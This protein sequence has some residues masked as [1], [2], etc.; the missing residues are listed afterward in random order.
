M[1]QPSTR[2][3][4]FD[5]LRLLAALQVAFFHVVNHLGVPLDR[6]NP[7]VAFASK[8][9]GVPIFFVVSGFLIS[10]S[11]ERS[12]RLASYARNRALRIYPALWVCLAVGIASA[13]LVGGIDFLRAD[14]IPWLAAQVTFGQFYN[15]DF[16][17]GYGVG[18]LNGSLWTIPVELQFYAFVPLLYAA[19]SLGSRR[20]NVAL[21]LLAATSLGA[22]ALYLALGGTESEVLAVKLFG[23]SLAPYL[24]MFLIGVLLQRNFDQVGHL[25]SGKGLIWL[26]A[27]AAFAFGGEG[28]GLR[29]G[30]NSPHP[31]PMA[32]LGCAAIA[33]AYSAPGWSHGLLRGNDISYGVYIYHAVVLNAFLAA[34]ATGTWRSLALVLGVSLSAALVSWTAIE[35]PALRLKRNAL[36]AVPGAR[37]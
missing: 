18:V 2:E 36:H 17:R 30:T 6:S 21:L 5:L 24:W 16:L 31:L 14:A 37:S 33:C 3:N 26:G 4:N 22:Q 20:G 25:L 15:P 9:P 1:N 11:W 34:G 35:R 19:L 28:L 7:L 23:V 29:V 27:Y 32:V 13:A 8:L 12:P 10:L